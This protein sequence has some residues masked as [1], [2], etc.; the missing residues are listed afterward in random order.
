MSVF[1][2]LLLGA[3]PLAGTAGLPS[4]SMASATSE[5]AAA[6]A[7]FSELLLGAS[8][9]RGAVLRPPNLTLTH[10]NAVW[11][12]TNY[13]FE[14]NQTYSDFGSYTLATNPSLGGDTCVCPKARFACIGAQLPDGGRGTGTAA[15]APHVPKS[16]Q[17][18]LPHRRYILIAVI[19]DQLA[20]LGTEINLGARLWDAKGEELV[21]ANRV[22]GMPASTRA[23]PGNVDGWIRYEWTFTTPPTIAYGLPMFE[24][25]VHNLTAMPHLEIADLAFVETAAEPLKPLPGATGL[26]F[27]GSAGSLPMNVQSCTVEGGI[28]TN[29]AN[30]TFSAAANTIQAFQNIDVSRQVAEWELEGVSLVGL[31]VLKFVPGHAGRCVLGNAA[32]SIGVQVDG[33]L[34]F[35]PHQDANITLTNSIGGKFNRIFNGH[36]LSEDDDGGFTV[37]PAIP[38]GSGRL[39]RWAVLTSG[40]QFPHLNATDTNSTEVLEPGWQ[41]SW[42]LSP[43]ERLF[44]SVMP[45]REY[46]WKQSFEFLWCVSCSWPT[47]RPTIPTP[48]SRP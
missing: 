34:G 14:Y 25:Y 10:P 16:A 30:Y 40:L 21:G 31:K 8:D 3:L 15:P 13:Q 20:R 4:S 2:W 43:G 24:E 39:A 1:W 37:T 29:A 7:G 27:R 18:L 46:D 35:V 9:P 5:P 48:C 26:T 23:I 38:L 45:M 6:P 44:A 28:A 32:I 47:Y 36:L 33:L 22:G 41:V 42:E 19:R 12:H 17:V 11:A